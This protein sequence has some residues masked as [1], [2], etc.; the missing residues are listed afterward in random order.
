MVVDLDAARKLVSL[1]QLAFV[2]TY[3][4][5]KAVCVACADTNSFSRNQST[6]VSS[7]GHG[8]L[9]RTRKDPGISPVA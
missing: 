5:E 8:S 9:R 2:N 3:A 1:P 4:C 6:K 7:V